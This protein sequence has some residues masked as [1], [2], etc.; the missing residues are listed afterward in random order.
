MLAPHVESGAVAILGES[1]SEAFRTGLGE[2]ASLRRLFVP[3]ELAEADAAETRAILRAVR[4]EYGAAMTDPDLDRLAELAGMYLAGTAEPGRAVGLLRRVI[5]SRADAAAPIKARDVLRTLATSTGVPVDLLDDE[6]PLDLAKVR[7]FFEAR[8]MGQPEAV[9][10]VI[11]LVALVKAGLNDPNKPYGALLFIGPTGVGKT[12]MARSLAELLFGDPARL[13]RFDMSEYATHDAFERLIGARGQPGL[14]TS[15]VRER[16]FSVVLLDEIEKAHLNAFDL[17]LQVLDAGRLT[18]DRGVTADF[19]RTIVILTSNLG[20]AVPTEAGLGFGP[21]GSVPPP[22]DR[23]HMLR[24]VLRFFR[25]E[26][27]N[28]L[29]QVVSFRPLSLETAE[30]IARREVA[31]VL[32]RGGLTRRRLAVDVDPSVLTLLLRH[33]YSPSF[34]ARPLKRTVE[35]FVLLPLAHALA[36]GA[37]TPGS[38]VRLTAHGDRVDVDIDVETHA[39]ESS[40]PALPKPTASGAKVKPPAGSLDAPAAAERARRLLERAEDEH[41]RAEPF[42]QRKTELL[43]R[44]RAQGFWSDKTAARRIL[45]EVHRL[46]RVVE[47]VAR[48]ARE[49]RFAADGAARK[50]AGGR[51]RS[52]DDRVAAAGRVLGSATALLDAAE[53]GDL[54]DAYVRVARVRSDGDALHGVEK[55]AQMLEGRAKRL[56]LDVETIDDRRGGDPV[57]DTIA[58]LVAGA[59]ARALLA[60]EAGFHQLLRRAGR[61]GR[62]TIGAGREWVRVEVVR[63][64]AGE[65]EAIR[66]AVKVRSKA[67]KAVT[68]RRIAK[69]TV[70]VTLLHEPSRVAVTGVGAEGKEK[71]VTRLLPFLLARVEASADPKGNPAPTGVVRRYHVGPDAKVVDRR[72]GAT[73]GHVDRVL[74]GELELLAL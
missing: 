41:R 6:V 36:R 57:E 42:A 18:D 20:A 44:T 5:E 29:D 60:S 46:E 70:E 69:P 30:Q 50:P 8:V 22:P 37:A 67:L 32:E 56:G 72:T 40:D 23:D 27:V 16:P 17:L 15:A 55:I 53:R 28:R 31:R 11:D 54:G 74:A 48:A 25:P 61:T 59:G 49:A 19:R 13:L 66:A 58:L 33:G 63:A 35:R 45:D 73:C 24:E 71:A 10:A 34:G 12:E 39:S 14:L 62:K 9:S 2:V 21:A 7:Q 65:P 38:L 4:D 64:P 1:T 3:V 26:F 51:P 43:A 68:G 47:V 52:D